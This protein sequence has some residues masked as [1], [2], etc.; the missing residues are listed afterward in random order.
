MGAFL[1]AKVEL[2]FRIGKLHFKKNEYYLKGVFSNWMSF[3][4]P[5]I[6]LLLYIIFDI[7]AL[8][9][10]YWYKDYQNILKFITLICYLS[11]IKKYE[12]YKNNRFIKYQLS[13]LLSPA[14]IAVY[15]VV[16]GITLNTIVILSNNNLMP[17]CPSL[18]NIT[19]Y[20]SSELINDGRH[21]LYSST[22]K[23]SF[24]IDWIDLGYTMM[25]P[26]DA[27]FRL[28]PFI[29]ILSSIKKANNY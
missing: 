17:V 11:L 18:S 8:T 22:T 20:Y 6:C 2:Y 10:H 23:L 13:F 26:G 15:C 21:I 1:W 9:R 24:L 5:L 14:M 28:Y 25:S 16:V 4:L 3:L 7:S 27:F 29:I 12:L 19:G